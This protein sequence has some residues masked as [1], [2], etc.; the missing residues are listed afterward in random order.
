MVIYLF[1]YIFITHML[2]RPPG[3]TYWTKL[4][5]YTLMMLYSKL[6]RVNRSAISYVIY[7]YLY[8]IYELIHHQNL[9]TLEQRLFQKYSLISVYRICE[10]FAVESSS[11]WNMIIKEVMEYRITSMM[12]ING[13]HERRFSYSQWKRTNKRSSIKY[14]INSYNEY[15]RD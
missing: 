4:W 13:L 9:S 2:R 14:N 3:W 1:I 6:D 15:D 7:T 12:Y 8:K 11:T 5:W 10:G